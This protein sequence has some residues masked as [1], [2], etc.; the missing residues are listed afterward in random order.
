M[1]HCKELVRNSTSEFTVSCLL[2]YGA[3]KADTNPERM[4]NSLKDNS[5]KIK[6]L[7]EETFWK[8]LAMDPTNSIWEGRG[9]PPH[10]IQP[11]TTHAEVAHCC[12]VC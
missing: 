7:L 2:R 9:E 5:L 8:R 10:M 6:S 3:L 11:G 12:V 1:S 4:S